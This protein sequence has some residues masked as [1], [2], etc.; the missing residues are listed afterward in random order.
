MN[1]SVFKVFLTYLKI[2]LDKI[3]AFF[4]RIHLKHSTRM[5]Y[6]I[7]PISQFFAFCSAFGIAFIKC[8]PKLAANLENNSLMFV[9]VCK[10]LAK[11]SVFMAQIRYNSIKICHMIVGKSLNLLNLVYRCILFRNLCTQGIYTPF[12]LFKFIF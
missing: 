1:F 3:F 8:L 10:C 6:G 9:Q 5:K 11:L 4:S 7:F 2:A 12:C